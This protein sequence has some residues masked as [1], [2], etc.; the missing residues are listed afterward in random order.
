MGAG[1]RVVE[2]C[3]TAYALHPARRQRMLYFYLFIRKK[4]NMHLSGLFTLVPVLLLFLFVNCS[5]LVSN[6]PGSNFQPDAS[7]SD[8]LPAGGTS[9]NNPVIPGFHPDPSIC[10]VDGDYYLVN[11]SFE[12][13]PGIPVFHSRNLVN[14]ELIGY[15]LATASQLDLTG[16]ASSSGIGAPT[17]RYNDGVYYVIATDFAG[18]G[19]F[20]VTAAN[21]A[22]PWS[23]PFYIEEE[24]SDPSL[25][26]DDDG[27][28]YYTSQEGAGLQSHIIQYEIDVSSG[29]LV[30]EKHFLWQ[31]TG[32]VWTEGPHLY[33]ID[34][35]YY[36]MAATGGTG[37][38]H[39]E[40]IAASAF[41]NG[42]FTGCPANPVLS[43][44]GTT[45]PIQCTGH[46]DLLLDLNGRWWAVF[47]G[48]RF[49]DNGFSMLGRETFLA[50]VH[51]D[52]GW[53]VIGDNGRAGLSMTGPLPFPPGPRDLPVSEDFNDAA[54]PAYFCFVR[55]PEPGSWSLNERPGWLRLHGNAAGLS[56][57]A[58]P[59]FVGRRQEHFNMIA[60]ARL[61]FSPLRAGEEAGLTV[62]LSEKAHYEIAI[63]KQDSG[64]AIIVRSCCNNAVAVV[65][66][67]NAVDTAY[68]L[69]IESTATEY[70]FSCSRDSLAF[71]TI[72]VLGAKA[73]SPESNPPT[74]TGAVIGMYA[75]GNGIP[76]AAPADFDW[77]EYLP[78]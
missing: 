64:S 13:F 31:G 21:P 70:A 72:A 4:L 25:F 65:G 41:P 35:S 47:L 27:R 1:S 15:C 68:L 57:R 56:D 10:R 63:V 33:K 29:R 12:Y 9:Y 75:T 78:Q 3:D 50:P 38:D 26:F 45:L 48:E 6:F 32:D 20:Y 11:S 54:L 23:S 36:L 62:R 74:Y 2:L 16:R 60:R 28:V 42:P 51:W 18:R 59:A 69:Q 76:C 40:I 61:S 17:I 30:G 19:N 53:P 39:Q 34:R 24:G 46:A 71:T 66:R 8:T 77:F 14:W 49:L 67:V 73:I 44:R 7:F 52:K 37:T 43:D 5:N 55:N 58:S 22:G